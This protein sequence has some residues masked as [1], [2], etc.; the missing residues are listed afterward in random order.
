[1]N[2][3]VSD[4]AE[5]GGLVKGRK[6]ITS[7]T[8]KAMKEI[9]TDIQTGKFAEE[10]IEENKNGQPVLNQL[11][12]ESESHPIEKVGAKLRQMMSWLKN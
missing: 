9:L 7:D 3:S 10:W 5:Y 12:K 4:T 8:K 6:V 2:Y 11:R 1:M